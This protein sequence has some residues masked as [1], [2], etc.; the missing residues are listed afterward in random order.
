ML[1]RL[2]L[3]APGRPRGRSARYVPSRSAESAD[4]RA[5]VRASREA[6]ERGTRGGGKSV[7]R[8]PRGRGPARREPGGQEPGQR[9]GAE[10][11]G[12]AL[13]AE[14]TAGT[15][16]SPAGVPSTPGDADEREGDPGDVPA[17]T[18]YPVPSDTP[19]AAADPIPP[20]AEAHEGPEEADH[21]RP[22]VPAADQAA[23]Q[24]GE[25]V[26]RLRDPRQKAGGAG[27]LA[28]ERIL[29][30]RRLNFHFTVELQL[31]CPAFR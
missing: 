14:P 2:K 26:P 6:G 7:A 31:K 28:A 21:R 27:R 19:A 18:A 10:R 12:A 4:N 25:A 9:G 3:Q 24:A 29:R 30:G 23:A 16:V 8:L 20:D 15:P 22:H 1:N 5:F 13:G 11:G 17:A